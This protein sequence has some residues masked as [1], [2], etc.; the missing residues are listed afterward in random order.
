MKTQASLLMCGALA[1]ALAAALQAAG[2]AD[3][4]DWPCYRGPSHNGVS[5]EVNWS[6]AKLGTQPKVLWTA[7]VGVGHS[8]IV[9][10]DGRAYVTG[11]TA[12]KDIV[13]CF[14]AATGKELWKSAYPC[15]A[16]GKTDQTHLGPR[17]S[18]A[19]DATRVYTISR[20]GDVYCFDAKTGKEVW[21]RNVVK[22]LDGAPP[23]WGVACSPYLMGNALI[24][25][26][27]AYGVVL[28][29]ATGKVVW[30]SPGDIGG[31]ASPV[32]FRNGDALCLAMF[33]K[34]AFHVVELK[35]GKELWSYSWKTRYDI[36]ASDPVV[37]GSSLFI[38]SGYERGCA[39]IE[40]KNNS[41]AVAWE[42]QGKEAMSTQFSSSVLVGDYL[43]GISGNTGSG[44]LTCLDPKTGRVKWQQGGQ[45]ES[46]NAAG[47]RL[48]ALTSKGELVVAE[49][50][51]SAYREFARAEVLSATDAS[52]WTAPVLSHGR[53]YCRNS[54][55]DLV[56]LDVS[57]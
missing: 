22:D 51:S 29:K 47:D 7:K 28:E 31:Y 13:Y 32:V 24:L 21:S 12:D 20:E 36:N 23:T 6:P 11:N 44:K 46:L 42:K 33:G 17:A 8:C 52:L 35:T 41:F 48:I 55:G 37:I 38:S 26:T 30:R 53:I 10:K 5:T 9:V 4:A 34:D 16:T 54:L 1:L 39:L 57:R 2:G 45:F 49:A 18:P 27:L 15:K 14:H 40:P 56:C 19:V 43:Y 3:G 25:N 50:S